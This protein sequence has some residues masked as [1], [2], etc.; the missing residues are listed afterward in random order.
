MRPDIRANENRKTLITNALHVTALQCQKANIM[1]KKRKKSKKLKKFLPV[2]LI[3]GGAAIVLFGQKWFADFTDK[4][5]NGI[6]YKFSNLKL[7]LTGFG[8]LQ[9]TALMTITN[10]NPIGGRVNSFTG[11]LKYGQNG[12]QIVPV[13]VSAFNL[14]ANGSAQA[15]II[16]QVPLLALA[17]NIQN[18][19]TAIS[20]GDY[21]KL[22]LTGNLN[23]TFA[24]IPIDTEISPLEA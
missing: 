6:G 17:G 9:V 15:N 20:N 22:W 12:Q 11:Q 24:Q 3:A 1:A 13:N 7:K 18:V 8:N 14:P 21:K 19:V 2:L 4:F 16:S 5:V 10:N 23:T